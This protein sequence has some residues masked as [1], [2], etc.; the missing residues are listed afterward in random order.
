M[1]GCVPLSSDFETNYPRLIITPAPIDNKSGGNTDVSVFVWDNVE[2]IM[3]RPK[4]KH[5]FVRSPST[6][7]SSTSVLYNS[8]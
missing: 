5:M 7:H 6:H 8:S 1:T 2:Y 3:I 4:I